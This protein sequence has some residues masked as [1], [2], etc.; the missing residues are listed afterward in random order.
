L[1]KTPSFFLKNGEN[2]LA[3]YQHR[4]SALISFAATVFLRGGLGQYTMVMFA[5]L[6]FLAS[7]ALMLY[8]AAASF[9]SRGATRRGAFI[10]IMALGLT[11]A[12]LGSI[13]PALK[14]TDGLSGDALRTAELDQLRTERDLLA[15]ELT[16]KVRDN[17]AVTKTSA[18]FSKLHKERLT[19]VSEDLR[20]VKDL[21]QG[22]ASGIALGLDGGDVSVTAFIDTPSGYEAI[23]ND[24]RRLKTIKVRSTD[25]VLAPTLAMF[26][27]TNGGTVG[28]IVEPTSP[29][30]PIPVVFAPKSEIVAPIAPPKTDSAETLAALKKA[31]DGR[32]AT[33]HYQVEPLPE[34]E[35]VAGRTGRYYSIELKQP[36]TADRVAFESARYT[37]SGPAKEDFK[38]A[39]NTFSGDVL[40]QLD[41]SVTYE[42]F[43]RG[44]ADNQSYTGVAEPG[45]DYRKVT[46][47]PTTGRG[48]H[49]KDVA[50]LALNPTIKNSDLPFLRAEFQRSLL[51]PLALNKSILALEGPVLKKTTAAARN[52]ELIVFVAW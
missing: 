10:L 34:T 5:T 14:L 41:G 18:F 29:A 4:F 45:F 47:L 20:I 16:Q 21:V 51:A 11:T 37:L 9:I 44:T 13:Y 36:K 46:Y 43:V 35:L 12:C 31:F 39:F 22:P 8:L 25:D 17:E 7:L 50:T 48:Q 52:T 23:L 42:L 2:Q 49:L 28:T 26:G 40:R 15:S 3:K 32:M 33:P 1:K 27:R 38:A 30:P 19:R 24:L 6:T